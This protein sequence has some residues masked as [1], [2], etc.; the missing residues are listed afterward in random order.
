MAM[1]ETLDQLLALQEID[2]ALRAAETA[3]AALDDGSALAAEIAQQEVT[4]RDLKRALE[5]ASAD[6]KDRELALATVEEKKKSAERRAYGGTVSNPRELEG[7]EKDIQQLAH[8]KDRLE[9]EILDLYDVVEQRTAAVEQQRTLVEEAR[10]RLERTR[11]EYAARLASINARLEELTASRVALLPA[12]DP[13]AL[14]QYETIRQRANN[15]GL[16]VAE[17]GVCSGCNVAIPSTTLKRLAQAQGLL[18]CDSCGRILHPG[19]A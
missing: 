4:L 14:R 2:T 5:S 11:D 17:N 7:L 8:Q 9:S 13:A 1:R 18:T 12:V 10:A 19:R 15:L 3:K 16:A 6:L